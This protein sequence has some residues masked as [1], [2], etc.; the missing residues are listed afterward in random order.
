MIM[1]SLYADD[2]V[3]LANTLEDAQKLMKGLECVALQP[4]SPLTPTGSTSQRPKYHFG[5]LLP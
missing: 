4:F 3:L 1:L 2:V 5:L